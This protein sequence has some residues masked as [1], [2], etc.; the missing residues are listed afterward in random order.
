VK[1]PSVQG[2]PLSDDASRVCLL[3]DPKDGRVVHVHGVT[4][5]HAKGVPDAAEVEAR[6]RKHAENF[7]RSTAGLKALH[8]PVSAVRENGKLRVNAKGDGLVP[9]PRRSIRKHQ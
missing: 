4:V 6:A 1:N 5:A 9:S 7:G 8:V 2:K 3:Y